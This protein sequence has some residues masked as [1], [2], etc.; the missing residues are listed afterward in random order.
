M[1]KFS[2]GAE[3]LGVDGLAQLIGKRGCG[4]GCG[5]LRIPGG[6]VDRADSLEDFPVVAG[7]GG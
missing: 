2:V 6:T 3:R 5:S 1:G 7:L 4:I